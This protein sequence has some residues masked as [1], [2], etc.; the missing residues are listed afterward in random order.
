M[1][2]RILFGRCGRTRWVRPFMHCVWIWILN[3]SKSKA[4]VPS[5]AASRY[6]LRQRPRAHSILILDFVWHRP[7]FGELIRRWKPG[8]TEVIT[9]RVLGPCLWL[10]TTKQEKYLARARPAWR[11]TIVRIYIWRITFGGVELTLSLKE[12]RNT[13][14]YRQCAA[15]LLVFNSIF[16]TDFRIEMIWYYIFK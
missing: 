15:P 7:T 4:R 11:T 12:V 5:T 3:M 2:N 6:S 1:T 13:N 16:A 8:S 9:S 10:T 14:D